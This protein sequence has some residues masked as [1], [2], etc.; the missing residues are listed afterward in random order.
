MIEGLVCPKCGSAL[1]VYVS[2]NAARYTI[3]CD[4]SECPFRAKGPV[5]G[6]F[7]WGK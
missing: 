2:N 3:L 6:H 5:D 4:N 7:K 1:K